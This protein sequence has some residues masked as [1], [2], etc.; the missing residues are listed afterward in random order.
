MLCSER[1]GFL[2]TNIGRK[3][4]I[5]VVPNTQTRHELGEALSRDAELGGGASSASAVSRE[6]SP[7]EALLEYPSG[8]LQSPCFGCHR[9]A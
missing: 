4:V 3:K 6:R 9:A 7:D 2:F 1:S 8:L 5:R